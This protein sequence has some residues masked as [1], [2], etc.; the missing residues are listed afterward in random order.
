MLQIVKDLFSSKKFL[1]MLS[2]I[3]I[4]VAS[5]LG[6]NID[7]NT[8]NQIL[9]IIAA[10]IVGQ[11]IADHGKEAVIAQS[12]LAAAQAVTQ[13]TTDEGPTKIVVTTVAPKGAVSLG[14]LVIML[15]CFMA[16][17][18]LTSS[19]NQV[20]P[21]ATDVID[22]AQAE[23]KTVA[24]GF[25]I[26]QVIN[27]VA[28]AIAGGPAGIEAAIEQLISKFGGE[29]VACAIDNYPTTPSAG[30]GSAVP[31]EHAPM[32]VAMRKSLLQKY[33]PGK[34]INHFTFKR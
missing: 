4:T 18:G 7:P 11:G 33:F 3:V 19:C 23:A 34:T 10:Y 29:I 30:S 16:L 9:A 31:T 22:C 8:L 20:Q 15:A 32:D 5:K 25:S 27:D 14:L 1:V 13:T 24:A 2:G 28:A 26:M 17:V 12:R 21:V 6:L